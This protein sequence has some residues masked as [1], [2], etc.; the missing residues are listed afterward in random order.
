MYRSNI[1]VGRRQVD[2]VCTWPGNEIE[3]TPPQLQM[4]WDPAVS[5]G[6]FPINVVGAPGVHGADVAGMQGI[7]VSTPSAAE[8]AAA[9]C[10]LARLMHIPNGGMFTIGALSMIVAAGLFPINTVGLIELRVAGAA[11]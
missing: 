2:W 4:H 10:G 1:C 11:P 5:A 6:L 8:V 7:G 3:M 9:T